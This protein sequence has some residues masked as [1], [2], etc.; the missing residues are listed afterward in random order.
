VKGALRGEEVGAWCAAGEVPEG[1]D[2]GGGHYGVVKE[3]TGALGMVLS[4]VCSK[5]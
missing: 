1:G 4:K 2:C 5:A 3:V